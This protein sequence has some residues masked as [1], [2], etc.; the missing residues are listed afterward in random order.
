MSTFVITLGLLHSNWFLA[1]YTLIYSIL[2]TIIGILGLP[3]IMDA[4]IY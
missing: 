1:N 2:N 4:F 3:A